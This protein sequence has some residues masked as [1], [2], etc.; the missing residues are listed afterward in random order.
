MW[1]NAL[2]LDCICVYQ[3]VLADVCQ[4][5]GRVVQSQQARILVVSASPYMRYLVSGELGSQPDLFVV[6]TARMADEIAY[7]QALL[8]PDLA[9][10]DLESPQDLVNLQ[11]TA[12]ELGLP[13]LALCSQTDQ[14]AELAFNALQAGAAEVVVRPNVDLGAVDFTPDLLCKVRSLAGANLRLIVERWPDL[15]PCPQATPRPFSHGDRL[16]VVSSSAGGLGPLLQLLTAIPADLDAA[17]LVFSSLPKRYLYWFLDHVD[18]SIAFR[19]Q[20]ADDGLQLEKGVAY[21]ALSDYRLT[22]VPP[23]QLKLVVGMRRNGSSPSIDA[24]LASVADQYGPEALCVILSGA[25]QDGVQ[26]ALKVRGAGG[27]VIVQEAV[28]CV[29]DGTPEA[30]IAAGAATDPGKRPPGLCPDKHPPGLCPDKHP[31]GLCPDKH[32][33]GLCPDKRPPGLCP[34]KHPPGLCPDKH[35]PGLCPDKHPPGLWVLSPE[36]IVD[37]IVRQIRA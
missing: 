17:L 12:L 32:P 31:P 2:C 1:P 5:E 8:R 6:G 30:V 37:E 10:V 35:P 36:Q 29:V 20:Q 34:D 15:A 13:V 14:G 3:K 16:I 23:G 27:T 4:G 28:T 21:F 7:K 11:Q 18:P 33:P 26:G 22:V 9:V 19:L 25:G 24:T